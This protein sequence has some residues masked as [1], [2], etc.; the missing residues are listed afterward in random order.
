LWIHIALQNSNY[1]LE[2]ELL[3]DDPIEVPPVLVV[4]S[5]MLLNAVNRVP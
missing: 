5:L 3:A 4:E 2:D 1:E